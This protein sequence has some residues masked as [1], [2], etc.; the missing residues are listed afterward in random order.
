MTGFQNDSKSQTALT[1]ILNQYGVQLFKQELTLKAPARE[2][3][4]RKHAFTQCLIRV[5][6]MYMTSR[7]KVTSFFIDDIQKLFSSKMIYTVWR[8][9]NL[10]EN[11]DFPIIMIL[12]FNVLKQNQSDF[13]WL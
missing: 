10:L 11:L 9:F 5:T 2:F 3:A 1:Y 4:Q 8:M 13:A 12:Q 6:D 7:A